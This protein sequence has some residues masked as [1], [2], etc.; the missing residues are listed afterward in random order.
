MKTVDQ[1]HRCEYAVNLYPTVAMYL[2]LRSHRDH[3]S[4]GTAASTADNAP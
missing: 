4:D 2:D 1:I 3:I